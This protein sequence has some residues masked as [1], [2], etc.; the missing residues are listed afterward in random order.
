MADVYRD[1]LKTAV[2]DDKRPQRGLR[3]PTRWLK[4]ETV[5][6]YEITFHRLANKRLPSLYRKLERQ[7]LTTLS[8]SIF[9]KDGDGPS[10]IGEDAAFLRHIEPVADLYLEAR[11]TNE[12]LYYASMQRRDFAGLY[13]FCTKGTPYR[14]FYVGISRAVIRRLRK[15]STGKRHNEATFLYACL[16]E[17][18]E[19][20]GVRSRIRMGCLV[21]Q[22]FRRWL[23]AQRVAILPL[24]NPVERYVFELYSSMRLRT[25]RWNHFETH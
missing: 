17:H 4:P 23:K 8:L 12:K 21:G 24:A 13:V 1:R 16:K 9:C 15:H 5:H 19:H 6:G 11:I 20:K 18:L 10:A 7:L 25:G 3:V 22:Y 14:P 2:K